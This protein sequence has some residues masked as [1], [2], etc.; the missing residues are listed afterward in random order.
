MSAR[1]AA[2][3]ALVSRIGASVSARVPA[4]QVLRNETTPQRV[5]AGG[6]IVIRDG[7]TIE[8]TPIL[9]P[10]SY[11]IEHAAE[12]EVIAPG[13]TAAARSAL[14]D[15]LLSDIAAGI[16]ANRTLGG[17][18]EWAEPAS[19]DFDDVPAEGAASMRAASFPVRLFFT[20][21]ASPLS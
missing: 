4:P 12:V 20:V 10:L 21:A 3:V 19:P 6:T 9:S 8:E 13:S 5:P 1:E 7:A 15:A 2:L 11:A 17:A 14:L 16:A 18:V